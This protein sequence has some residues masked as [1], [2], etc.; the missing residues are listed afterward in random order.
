MVKRIRKALIVF[1]GLLL[2][3]KCIS[4]QNIFPEEKLWRALNGVGNYEAV[5]EAVAQGL[6]LINSD[7]KPIVRKHGAIDW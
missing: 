2:V 6:M 1:I 3:V 5:K 4:F 7:G